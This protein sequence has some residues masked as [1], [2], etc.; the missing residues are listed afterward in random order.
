MKRKGWRVEEDSE[1][2]KDSYM[3]QRVRKREKIERFSW[4]FAYISALLV[5]SLYLKSLSLLSS[6]LLIPFFTFFLSFFSPAALSFCLS[7]C[8]SFSSLLFL[9]ISCLSL[10]FFL[11]L[12]L[13]IYLYISTCLYLSHRILSFWN[14]NLFTLLY[15]CLSPSNKSFPIFLSFNPHPLLILS[16]SLH[17]SFLYLYLSLIP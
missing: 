5:L 15:L 9:S 6:L 13:S 10:P 8:L 2:E 1:K 4:V 16:L 11:S 14:L 12:S 7:K 3:G 17:F